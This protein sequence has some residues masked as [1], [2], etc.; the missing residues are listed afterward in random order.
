MLLTA[1][2]ECVGK[3]GGPSAIGTIKDGSVYMKIPVIPSLK[4]QAYLAALLLGCAV[5]PGVAMAQDEV[6]AAQ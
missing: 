3:M 2:T 4:S 6:P 5:D 1:N